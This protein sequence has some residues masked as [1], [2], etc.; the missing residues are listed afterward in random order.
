MR[1]LTAH[2]GLTMLREDARRTARANHAE[3]END[4][5][6]A[7]E[8]NDMSCLYKANRVNMGPGVD[9]A[10]GVDEAYGVD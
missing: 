7:L 4:V 2:S 5:S 8:E 1:A 6:E 3:T 10:F 9:G